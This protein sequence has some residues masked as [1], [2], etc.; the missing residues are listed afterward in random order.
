VWVTLSTLRKLGLGDAVLTH[1]A[2]YLIDPEIRVVLH[3]D[4]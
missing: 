4:A 2:G 1:E 3:N